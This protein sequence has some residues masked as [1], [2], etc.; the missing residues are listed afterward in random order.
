MII[1]SELQNSS[2]KHKICFHH[3]AVAKLGM[4][5][6]DKL[7]LRP[8]RKSKKKDCYNCGILKHEQKA[9]YN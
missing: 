3:M 9:C 1:K 4:C 7:S 6:V 2:I 8:T 5:S